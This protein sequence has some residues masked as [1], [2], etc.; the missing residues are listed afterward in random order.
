VGAGVRE[1]LLLTIEPD[2][3]CCP[4]AVLG[5]AADCPEAERAAL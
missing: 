1:D 3:R 5:A 4:L 2:V